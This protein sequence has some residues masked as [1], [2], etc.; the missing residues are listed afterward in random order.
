[1][2]SCRSFPKYRMVTAKS[3]FSKTKKYRKT[4]QCKVKQRN[5]QSKITGFDEYSLNLPEALEVSSFKTLLPGS[6]FWMSTCMIPSV[7][8]KGSS[9]SNCQDLCRILVHE[10]I[11]FILLFDGYGS[12]GQLVSYICMQEAEDFFYTSY[13]KYVKDN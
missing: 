12:E 1:M 5:A 7:N 13:T 3:L 2:G 4:A 9:R 8:H 11:I 10:E 6:T